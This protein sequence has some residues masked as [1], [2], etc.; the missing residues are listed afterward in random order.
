[1]DFCLLVSRAQGIGSGRYVDCIW[2]GRLFG[3]WDLGWVTKL[4]K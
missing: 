4:G 2:M 3:T 1:M